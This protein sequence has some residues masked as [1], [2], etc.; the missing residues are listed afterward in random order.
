MPKKPNLDLGDCCECDKNPAV[1][2]IIKLDEADAHVMC[3]TCA[4]LYTSA[5]HS[6]KCSQDLD[7]LWN[8]IKGNSRL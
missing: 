7:D 6:E 5:K 8:E 1:Y 2:V 3:D 4:M